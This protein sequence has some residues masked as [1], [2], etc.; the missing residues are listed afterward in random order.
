MRRGRHSVDSKRLIPVFEP[1]EA[2]RVKDASKRV[3]KGVGSTTGCLFQIVGAFYKAFAIQ[4]L[5]NWFLASAIHGE[6]LS[7][8]QALG[9][10]ML[11]FLFTNSV[12]DKVEEGKRT[13]LMQAYIAAVVPPELKDAIDSDRKKLEQAVWYN[14][15]NSFGD[16]ATSTLV[17]VV[18]WV[19]HTFLI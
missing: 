9:I 3:L 12:T 2:F 14:Q 18:G 5:W 6:E 1:N 7:Y 13:E 10:T 4:S 15:L 8:F 17:L 19:I 11:F 16:V